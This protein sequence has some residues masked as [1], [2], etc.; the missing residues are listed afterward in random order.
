MNNPWIVA[1][2]I[3]LLVLIFLLA[4]DAITWNGV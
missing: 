1:I 2:V 4:A 3:V